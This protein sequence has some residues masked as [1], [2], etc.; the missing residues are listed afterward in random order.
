[1]A[2]TLTMREARK[3]MAAQI[4]H[5]NLETEYQVKVLL[6]VAAILLSAARHEVT[7]ANRYQVARAAAPELDMLEERVAKLRIYIN[8]RRLSDATVARPAV[9]TAATGRRPALR[10]QAEPRAAPRSASPKRT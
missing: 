7:P 1:M 9:T 4:E 10:R 5:A 2:N 3:R 6:Q 8:R